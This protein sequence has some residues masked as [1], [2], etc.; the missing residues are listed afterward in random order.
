[1]TVRRNTCSDCPQ[2]L[3]TRGRIGPGPD[4]VEL[5]SACQYLEVN[6]TECAS[7]IFRDEIDMFMGAQIIATSLASLY[8]CVL[9]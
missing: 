8:I 5:E 4:K 1:M 9:L 3:S 2:I 7:N 6:D